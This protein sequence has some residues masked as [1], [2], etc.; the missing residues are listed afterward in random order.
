MDKLQRYLDAQ[1]ALFDHVGV[2][3]QEYENVLNYRM[4]LWYIEN[5]VLHCKNSDDATDS[6]TFYLVRRTAGLVMICCEAEN[7]KNTLGWRAFD[8]QREQRF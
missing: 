3:P 5:N 4:D 6:Y 8:P 2:A 7:V 1:R